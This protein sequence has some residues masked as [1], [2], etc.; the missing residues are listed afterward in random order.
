MC[1]TRST[2]DQIIDT[3]SALLERQG[4]A[5]TGLN[6]I[7][8]ESGAPKG[9]LYHYFPGG[10]DEIA[11][12]ALQQGAQ[13]V[14]ERIRE[15]LIPLDDPGE[16][17]KA[18]ILALAEMQ[19]D[20]NFLRGAPLAAVALEAAAL[21]PRLS[22]TIR[23]GYRTWQDAFRDK[24]ARS[25]F[26][27]GR[28]DRLAGFIVS[29]IE[30]AVLLGRVRRSTEPLRE[31]AD[32]LE[33]LIGR[34]SLVDARRA[35]GAVPAAAPPAPAVPSTPAAA[36]EPVPVV[37]RSEASEG[38]PEETSP[39][40][41]EP[42]PPRPVTLDDEDLPPALLPG[43]AAAPEQPPAADEA[44]EEADVP[45]WRMPAARPP[46]TGPVPTHAPSNGDRPAAAA[47]GADLDAPDDIPPL[48][49]EA[50]QRVRAR[51]SLRILV[52]GAS[53]GTGC[54]L[55]EQALA[56]GHSVT[57]LARDPSAI[58]VKHER[59]AVVKGDVR[60]AERMDEV[61][62][63]GIDAVVSALGPTQGATRDMITVGTG[64]IVS[65]M[66]RHD[67]RRLVVMM[68]ADLADPHDE[69][70]LARSMGLRL[71][72]LSNG[73]LLEDWEGAA[74]A[75]RASS[76]DWTIVRAARLTDGPRTSFYLTG[77]LKLG[78]NHSIARGDVAEFMLRQLNDTEFLREAP[79]ISY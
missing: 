67:V 70:T 6:Q 61:I 31:V 11:V 42:R 26:A 41:E 62:A 21:N 9:S 37:Q 68:G 71:R 38:A 55:I 24:L 57:A 59:L 50:A 48:P 53:G 7:V 47:H 74:A 14:A 36:I 63:A 32:D 18:Y 30:G 16:A 66:E 34:R 5:A 64:N 75:I 15:A 40:A 73:R 76:L 78:T 35:A 3:A 22:E 13:A 39:A 29:A 33:L 72:R 54:H 44:P 52:I 1:S 56:A 46:A 65:A 69:I 77:Y 23:E 28:A 49:E 10:K 60:N 12:E 51:R 25:N 17:I 20:S 19:R 2:R 27:G 45:V 43:R 8:R 79:L 4:Y 58:W